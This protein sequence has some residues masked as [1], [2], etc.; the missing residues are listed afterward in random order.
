M[1]RSTKVTIDGI[2][3][4][5]K[6]EARRYQELCLLQAAGMIDNLTCHPQYLLLPAFQD[7]EGNKIRAMHYTADFTYLENGKVIVEDVKTDASRTQAYALRVKLFKYFHRDL[8][9]RETEG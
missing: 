1:S 7:N 6:A 8:Y 2:K 9:F 5:S 3:F 4:D